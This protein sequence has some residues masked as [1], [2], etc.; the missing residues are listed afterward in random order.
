M[1]ESQEPTKLKQAAVQKIL[2]KGSK[3]NF[4]LPDYNFS[5]S[6]SKLGV[7]VSW[8]IGGAA[9]LILIGGIGYIVVKKKKYE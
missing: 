3:F 6:D 4:I 8:I 1:K 2:S 5:G 7:S 9:T